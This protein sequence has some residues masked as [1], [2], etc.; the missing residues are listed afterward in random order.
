MT[1]EYGSTQRGQLTLL[2]DTRVKSGSSFKTLIIT[3]QRLVHK[4]MISQL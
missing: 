3:E 2:N 1:S 4:K